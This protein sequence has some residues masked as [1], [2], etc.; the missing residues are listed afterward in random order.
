[1]SGG[2]LTH[3]RWAIE[4]SEAPIAPRIPR[5]AF[6]LGWTCGIWCFLLAAA[7]ADL[8]LDSGSIGLSPAMLLV[9][10]CLLGA[11]LCLTVSVA[12]R[13]TSA[14]IGA[15]V[16]ILGA[17]LVAIIWCVLVRG[18]MA[19][20]I[21][22]WGP[23]CAGGIVATQDIY[24]PTHVVGL[25]FLAWVA[26]WFLVVNAEKFREAS[27]L[28][29]SRRLKILELETLLGASD[30]ETDRPD[31]LWIPGRG[32]TSRVSIGDILSLTA[33]REYVRI[34]TADSREFLVR[35]SLAALASRLDP[36]S[37]LRIHRSTA[38]N[39][40]RLISLT[41]SKDGS[42]LATMETG[43]QFRVSRRLLPSIRAALRADECR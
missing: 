18:V 23:L 29:H 13:R 11:L 1:M 43:D 24:P 16:L 41:G 42:A 37:F 2:F 3:D 34:R 20:L 14:P 22:G 33:E 10:A 27:I 19:P 26:G 8:I 35:C 5:R 7:G 12:L 25:A 30:Q 31:H 39:L 21:C 40:R 38:I 4:T 17:S 15:G 6:V 32:G 36:D 9:G 28:A